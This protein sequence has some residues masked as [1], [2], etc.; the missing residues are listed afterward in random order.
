MKQYLDLVKHI[1]SNGVQKNDRTGTGT[2]SVFWLS[3]AFQSREDFRWLQ[4]KNC[5]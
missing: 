5:I 1:K 4:Q 3:N 2:L